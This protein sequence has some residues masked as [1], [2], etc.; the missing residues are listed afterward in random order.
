MREGLKH[1]YSINKLPLRI[2]SCKQR[3]EEEEQE[4]DMEEEEEEE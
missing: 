2:R 3:E 1:Y 4:E